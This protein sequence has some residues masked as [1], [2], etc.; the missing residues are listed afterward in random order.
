[1]KLNK[2]EKSTYILIAPPIGS[3]GDQ[4]MGGVNQDINVVSEF[5]LA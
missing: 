4:I 1:M 5:S 3:L 2:K